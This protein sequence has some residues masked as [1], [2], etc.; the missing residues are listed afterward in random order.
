VLPRQEGQEQG[1]RQGRLTEDDATYVYTVC[2]EYDAIPFF[3]VGRFG[4]QTV[5]MPDEVYRWRL[6]TPNAT[7]R[8]PSQQPNDSTHPRLPE[9]N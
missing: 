3:W 4:I 5:L 1:W 2:I 8:T 9:K 7:R 6:D